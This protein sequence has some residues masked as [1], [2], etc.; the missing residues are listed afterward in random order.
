MDRRVQLQSLRM[1]NFGCYSDKTIQFK[2]GLNQLV[3]RNESG[4]STVLRAV[5][6]A[7]FESGSTSKK[8]IRNYRSW[9][10]QQ[11]MKLTL[12]FSAA[13]F[14]YTLVRDHGT[15]SDLLVD[16]QDGRWEGKAIG[17]MLT[18]FFGTTDCNLFQSVF[19]FSSEASDA[20]DVNR[21]KLKSALEIPVFF[22]FDRMK[23]DGYLDEQIKQLDN[24]GAHS[25]RELDRISEQIQKHLRRKNEIEANLQKILPARKELSDVKA[26]I[27]QFDSEI[28][29]LE[30]QLNGANAYARLDQ[31]MAGL[32]QRLHSHL[33]SLSRATQADEDR[34][35]LQKE[36]DQITLPDPAAFDS[37]IA[38]QG[39]HCEAVETAKQCMDTMIERRGRANRDF[40]AV[41]LL[42]TV[43]CLCYVIQHFQYYDL[44]P[45]GAFI[46]YLLPVMVGAWVVQ[47]T[48]YLVFYNRKKAA[49]KVFRRQLE[50]LD[51]FY[52][53]LN[54]TYNLKAAD[55]V[56]AI[57][58]QATRRDALM[59]SLDNLS[60]TIDVLSDQQGMAG[61]S[62]IK[63]QLEEEIAVLNREME[64]VMAYASL[65]GK[66]TELAE[67]LSAL[68]VR[69]NAYREQAAVLAER[70]GVADQ[71][72]QHI[73]KIE[74]EIEALKRKHTALTERFEALRITRAAL[75]KA[76]D[77]LI[78][79]T[80]NDFSEKATTQLSNITG[81]DGRSVRF[82]QESS[83]F[84]LY[85]PVTDRWHP[86]DTSV[87]LSTRDAAYIA[88]RLAAA[89][90]II[91]E[92]HC[93]LFFDQAAAH[94]DPE[95]RRSFKAMINRLSER[96]QIISVDIEP[97]DLDS[98]I[99]E[100]RTETAAS[101]IPQ[102]K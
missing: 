57:F 63:K 67:K 90:H 51:Q 71:M 85:I 32:E 83:Q 60:Q 2:S 97:F 87:S 4:K 14:T 81:I 27:A 101:R 21:D 3:G 73:G 25:P 91:D 72:E 99:I 30:Q 47:M 5:I 45:V 69:A 37:L 6:T 59:I 54:D 42:L 74:D 29:K 102:H 13:G 44:G 66:I 26:T 53:E 15:G 93:P 40:L 64:P 33:A 92:Y 7:I 65:A 95:R 24:P 31:K 43:V 96:R 1:E 46:P 48:S 98:H 76:A 78:E 89:G 56:K 94:F 17:D 39:Q 80:F 38:S 12:I 41:T 34:Q 18:R 58:E 49:T 22:G 19:C 10:R 28:P 86:L 9:E 50:G 79:E 8:N 62:E 35:K 77:R 84:E 23:A 68:R 55:P 100:C 36:L 88:L 75:N 20:I 70:C 61:L 11:P 82:S 16:N 52:N